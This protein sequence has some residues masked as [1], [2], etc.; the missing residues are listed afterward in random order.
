MTTTSDFTER[1]AQIISILTQQFPDR[2]LDARLVNVKRLEG[3]EEPTLRLTLD[4][5]SS[6]DFSRERIAADLENVESLASEA[7]DELEH[8]GEAIGP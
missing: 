4:D 2:S 3:G 6:T 1:E 8:P 5:S 7:A